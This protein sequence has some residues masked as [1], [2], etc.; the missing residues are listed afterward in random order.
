M[1]KFVDAGDPAFGGAAKVGAFKGAVENVLNNVYHSLTAYWS[2]SDLKFMHTTNPEQFFAHY[3]T[4]NEKGLVVRREHE[5]N[6]TESKALGSLV[7]C[8]MLEPAVYDRDF[9]VMPNLNLRTNEGKAIKQEI[10]AKNVGK[11]E[12]SD[13]M[14]VHA[15]GMR[16]KIQANA[17]AMRLL[18]VGRKEASFYWTCKY[19]GLNF[20]SKLDQS[21]SKHFCELKTCRSASP[22]FFSK[23]IHDRNYDLSLY[24]YRESIRNVMDVEPPAHFIVVEPEPP[25]TCQ[26]YDAGQAVFELG[27]HKWLSAVD[28]LTNALKTGIWSGYFPDEM[29]IE[30]NPPP[31]AVNKLLKEVNQ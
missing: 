5:Q 22:E 16:S 26:V 25:Y 24:H 4:K 23:E 18:E 2:S 17:K 8:L 1:V 30:I 13:E 3:Y 20:R 10:L 31:W 21:S 12:I 28:R 29:D 19:S 15:N 14:L 7:H 27:H 6:W 11:I 9:F